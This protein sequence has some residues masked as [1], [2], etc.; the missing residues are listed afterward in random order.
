MAAAP[1][2]DRIDDTSSSS[3]EEEGEK[4][5]DAKIQK[6]ILEVTLLTSF[7]GF[8][9]FL[10]ESWESSIPSAIKICRKL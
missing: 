6:L 10:E 9:L 5:L 1:E 2:S 3:D 4:V 8:C 7:I